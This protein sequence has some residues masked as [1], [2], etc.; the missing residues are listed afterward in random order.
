MFQLLRIISVV[1]LLL[2]A[3]C[4]GGGGDSGNESTAPDTPTQTILA[5]KIISASIGGEVSVLPPHTLSGTSITIPP[6][7]LS[8]DTEITISISA[9]SS[10]AGF[11][12][13][14][15][16]IGKDGTQF[17][18]KAVVSLFYD[19]TTLPA[20][21]DENRLFLAKVLPNGQL[22]ALTNI[23]VDTTINRVS[24]ETSSLSD[25]VIVLPTAPGLI[26]PPVADAGADHTATVDS[27]VTLNASSS[28]DADGDALT[29]LWAF[30]SRP[31]GSSTTLS[32]DRALQPT[33]LI[34]VA[35][36]YV[37]QLIVNDGE[38][39]S[40]TDTVTISTTNSAPIANA[41]P[42]QSALVGERV[43]FDAS[44]SFDIDGN[45]LSYLWTFTT[46]PVGSN[47]TLSDAA[48]LSPSFIIDQ[49][50]TYI[51]QLIVNDGVV[52][53]TP[54]NIIVTT[55]NSVPTAVAGEDQAALVGD[56]ITLNGSASN[57]VD[58][59]ALTYAWAITTAPQGSATILTASNTITPELLIDQLG[60]YVVQLVVN[61]GML[62]STPDS[63]IITTGNSAPI[64]NAGLDQSISVGEIFFLDGS[65]SSDL[66][67]DSLSYQ[68]SFTS[69]PAGSSTTLSNASIATPSA[70]ADAPG[71]YVAQLI[72][73]DGTVDSAPDSIVLSTNNSRPV[74]D[75]GLDQ[76][77]LPN[78]TVILDGS[79]ST[80]ADVDNL[81]YS[82]A[83]LS[84]PDSSLST[85]TAPT[86]VNP[87]I[88]TDLAGRYVLQLIVNDGLLDSV[89][90][91]LTITV[92]P[93]IRTFTRMTPAS[94]PAGTLVTL[95]GD[96][97]APTASQTLS[98]TIDQPLTLPIAAPI[99]SSDNAS[100][101]ITV[102]AGAKSGRIIINIGSETLVSA[103]PFTVEASSNF[104]LNLEPSAG[105]VIK[106][107]TSQ[108]KVNVSSSDGFDKLAKL[109]ITGL[110]PELSGT[111][112][113]NAITAGQ[114]AILTITALNNAVEGLFNTQI[115]ATATVDGTTQLQSLTLPLTI[116]PVTTTLTGTVTLDDASETPLEG[117]IVSF[118]GLDE[119]GNAT[120][121]SASTI[122]DAA[123]NFTFT[124][125]PAECLGHQVVHFDAGTN[126]TNLP[127]LYAQVDQQYL[128]TQDQIA[129]PP[130]AV[131]LPRL[132]TS[133]SIQIIQN[134]TEDQHFIFS[135]IPNFEITVYAGTTFTLPDGTKPD[136]FTLYAVELEADRMPGQT[137]QTGDKVIPKVIALQP[138][139]TAISQQMPVIY[140][141]PINELPGSQLP[142]LALN[143]LQG[144]LMPYGTGT[145]SPNGQQIIPDPDPSNPGQQYGLRYL[146]WFAA[147]FTPTAGN[148]SVNPVARPNN[149]CG[150]L[151]THEPIDYATGLEI[152]TNVDLR[153]ACNRG[154]ILI[155][156]VFRSL[157]TNNGPFGLGTSHN[158]GYRLDTATPQNVELVNLVLPNGALVPLAKPNLSADPDPGR[159]TQFINTTTPGFN[160]SVLTTNVDGESTYRWQDGRIF[161]FT[162]D[163]VLR[164]SHLTSITDS[165]GNT[166]TLH[167]NPTRPFEIS[168]IEDAVGRRVSLQYDAQQRITQ[169]TDPIGRTVTY[170]YL[171]GML[172]SVTNQ[173]GGVT[174]FEYDNQNR[175]LR[176]F[177]ARNVKLMENE[178][179]ANGRVFR[180]TLADSGVITLDYI[181][182]NPAV[183]ISPV[184]ETRVT[185]AMGNSITYRFN[186]LGHL[187]NV[188]DP[189]GQ[190]TEFI[191]A[192]VTNRL[193]AI[194]RNAICAACGD[195]GS[196]N[197]SFEYDEKGNLITETD[198]LGN[199]V[200]LTYDQLHDKVASI[201]DPLGF[202]SRVEY[203]VTEKPIKLTDARN[204][205]TFIRY[206]EFGLVK[207]AEDA[208][209]NISRVEYDEFAN[210]NQTTDTLGNAAT[211]RYD[212][213]SRPIETLDASGNSTKI[214]YDKLDR[215]TVL[216]D[217][218]GNITRFEYD[219]VSNRTAVV[220]ARGKRTEFVYNEMGYLTSR[221][222]SLLKSDSR[223]YDL[224]GNLTQ[225]TNRNGNISNFEYDN[226]NRLTREAYAD[227]AVI[228]RDYNAKNRLASV[229]DSQSGFY[230][231]DYD[232]L[233]RL[234]KDVGPTGTVTYQY[235]Q[236]GE[237]RQRQVVGQAAV[238]Y[239]YNEVGGMTRAATA[240]H[241][242][243]LAYDGR[244]SLTSLQRSNGVD[245]AYQYDG[246]GRLLSITHQKGAT[247]L[248][249][250]SY[251]YDQI[252]N[253]T[254]NT[255]VFNKPQQTQASTNTIDTNSNRMLTR[256]I[257]SYSYD[258]NGNR[259][260]ETDSNSGVTTTYHW[261]GRNRL[262]QISRS[263][264]E[265]I[266]FVYDYAGNLIQQST[267]GTANDQAQRFVLD[268]F[269]NVVYQNS[270]AGEN[271]S[272]LTG[273][274][275]DQHFAV[276]KTNLQ[277]EFGLMDGIN[278]TVATTNELGNV[279]AEYFYENFGEASLGGE[280]PFQFTGRQL[281]D[282]GIYYYR[283]RFY[284]SVSGVF[285]SED[286]IGFSGGDVNITR[287]VLNR[288]LNFTD[289]TGLL[290][291][292]QRCMMDKH[293]SRK[294]LKN[295]KAV[296]NAERIS[297]NGPKRKLIEDGYEVA[298]SFSIS[299]VTSGIA[300]LF[301]K[302]VGALL[303]GVS[304]NYSLFDATNDAKENCQ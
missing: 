214:E 241:S 9:A 76:N 58:G 34:D 103:D 119:L 36:E 18:P 150:G 61:D 177:D 226:L 152:I 171:G 97:L 296:E 22:L 208:L 237:M 246:S 278:S 295:K 291:T 259:L 270:D 216:T 273:Q 193:L 89:T 149:S 140:P 191:R 31:N 242:I 138:D 81:T 155:E 203:D 243:D 39:D 28:S 232:A 170:S 279:N 144:M 33:F 116:V 283:A 122:A 277:S 106:G 71:N 132:D 220:D 69:L 57:D 190:T 178:Y 255:S 251:T 130:V 15:I 85:L 7:A 250:Q 68:W 66:D 199:T 290:T 74:A 46:R 173:E 196:G 98:V 264:G 2:L 269:T 11:I 187:L 38:F 257:V 188:V 37:V 224:N 228:T 100:I 143:P 180:Q 123:G 175:L 146:D 245:T 73:N 194:R 223:I 6:N 197:V 52:N 8:V 198:A 181:L 284:D 300:V 93:I 234:T 236:R 127:G 166:V 252:N 54:D 202:T 268:L 231:F 168:Q 121:C 162:P 92:A 218:L 303:D 4:S 62:S 213:V 225:F 179:D 204:N 267:I 27:T 287:Y 44:A 209:G 136:P 229:D 219:A 221:T 297:L 1:S 286:P 24:G 280:F 108:F 64:A 118:S 12:G 263:N 25:F 276:L 158:Y 77:A 248:G 169:I 266:D 21:F 185:D 91:T 271:Y 131:H 63:L 148:N 135:F 104:Q 124:N 72:V 35:G 153:I 206:D 172:A 60:T 249:E 80:D 165:K 49:P 157:S 88:T 207:E 134:H 201:T 110:P 19:E 109:A 48:V 43:T 41:G 275:I 258:D 133:E 272:V 163:R 56:T 115:S 247:V 86:S 189:I 145:V 184:R 235:N 176:E 55:L 183:G 254:S 265:T 282:G 129:T 67:G 87:T 120:G 195:P 227:G 10:Q 111:F 200:T 126:V 107:T 45:T 59:D 117:V 160:N 285:A 40:V 99:A 205:S 23:A 42:D 292:F 240:S 281:V 113:P 210:V 3:A 128:V 256:G 139:G 20:G 112:T 65:N 78:E 299:S 262:K 167:R 174:R 159:D 238:D 230:S 212:A 288:P 13:T 253:R 260:T 142:L 53:S 211:T 137:P 105:E 79:A 26:Q 239:L 298:K 102:P 114:S 156:R 186:P 16:D 301:G 96:N 154:G 304:F 17:N 90:D 151:S 94:G 182:S 164:V 101:T 192:P 51:T 84:K 147:A 233:G 82:W 47:A 5:Q 293:C 30:V 83:V 141:N 70:A 125:L 95:E 289:P 274:G 14:I 222:D 244:N 161:R 302:S 75:A 294:H 215:P 32:D 29:Y 261:D 217:A 50:G